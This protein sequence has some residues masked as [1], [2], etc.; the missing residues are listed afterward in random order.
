M[1][2]SKLEKTV[3]NLE[4]RL[5]EV[6]VGFLW[7]G[8]GNSKN[9]SW[10]TQMLMDISIAIIAGNIQWQIPIAIGIIA[11]AIIWFVWTHTWYNVVQTMP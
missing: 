2:A 11:T 3:V 9:H 5:R 4:R 8:S 6:P 10:Y 7:N 1:S